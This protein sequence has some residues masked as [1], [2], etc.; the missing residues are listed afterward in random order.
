MDG[1]MDGWMDGKFDWLIDTNTLMMAVHDVKIRIPQTI[2]KNGNGRGRE[3]SLPASRSVGL[4]AAANFL[5]PSFIL[6]SPETSGGLG[7]LKCPTAVAYLSTQD[8]NLEQSHAKVY[9]TT[10]MCQLKVTVRRASPHRQKQQ[11]RPKTATASGKLPRVTGSATS[12]SH[13]Y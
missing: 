6:G 5:N 11:R 8:G 2:G 1:W 3:T 10:G 13:P 12:T 7:P 9:N 4:G